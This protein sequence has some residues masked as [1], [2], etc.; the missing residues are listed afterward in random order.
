MKVNLMPSYKH[1]KLIER[2]SQIDELPDNVDEYSTWTKADEHLDLLQENAQ[3]A[4][5][6]TFP[7]GGFPDFIGKFNDKLTLGKRFS[8]KA[9]KPSE[10]FIIR[11]VILRSCYRID[12]FTLLPLPVFMPCS[13]FTHPFSE[14]LLLRL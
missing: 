4:Y 10:N 3:E 12:Q 8:G 13:Q 1:N 5:I 7:G 11:V 9:V 14:F 6:L 2:V